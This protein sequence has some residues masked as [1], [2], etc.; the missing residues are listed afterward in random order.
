MST[1]NSG[2]AHKANWSVKA[3]IILDSISESPVSLKVYANTGI[4]P[5][6]EVF[7]EYSTSHFIATYI[8][9]EKLNTMYYDQS[10]SKFIR[11]IPI[12]PETEETKKVDLDRFFIPLGILGHNIGNNAGLF[13]ILMEIRSEEKEKPFTP[14]LL[15]DCNIYWRIMKVKL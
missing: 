2:W 13:K 6:D 8:K 1:A 10:L 11:D 12:K 4:P 15:V 7:G 14:A 3:A 9:R 5:I